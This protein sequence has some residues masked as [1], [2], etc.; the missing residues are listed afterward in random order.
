MTDTTSGSATDTAKDVGNTAKQSGT[1]VASHA[2][3]QAKNVAGTAGDQAKEVAGHATEQAKQVAGTAADQARNLLG[4]AQSRLHE[5][6]STQSEK[7][8]SSLRA[9]VDELGAMTRHDG[10]SGPATELASRGKQYAQDAADYLEGKQPGDLFSDLRGLAGRRPGAFLVGALLAGVAAGRLTRGMV[11]A[12]GGPNPSPSLPSGSSSQGSS[13]GYVSGAPYQ[14]SHT[15]V[16]AP[17]GGQ[18]PSSFYEVT[19]PAN[20]GDAGGAPLYPPRDEL[21]R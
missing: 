10:P 19:E 2:T 5:E 15:E 9:L 21:L 4:E 18:P 6:A 7:A 20:L 14:P 13:Q 11:A 1:E 16:V 3:D 8:V 12:S 17:A